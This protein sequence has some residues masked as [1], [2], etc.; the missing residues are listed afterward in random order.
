[1]LSC[2]NPVIMIHLTQ[3]FTT[4]IVFVFSILFPSFLYRAHLCFFNCFPALQ[5]H[6]LLFFPLLLLSFLHFSFPI[7]QPLQSHSPLFSF[8]PQVTS[9]GS[10]N[11]SQPT[12][13]IPFPRIQRQL[14]LWGHF[15]CCF[16][17]LTAFKHTHSLCVSH[18]HIHTLAI[19]CNSVTPVT[20]MNTQTSTNKVTHQLF[21][22]SHEDMRPH[23]P[24]IFFQH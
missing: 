9:R 12:S 21:L 19:L 24:L 13:L 10:A 22:L 8:L 15:L 23:I 1:M 7:L 18:T 14:P 6:C 3:F 2:Y 4:K 5:P 11:Q 16:N 20:P 17:T